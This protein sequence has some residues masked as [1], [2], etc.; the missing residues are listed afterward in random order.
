MKNIIVAKAL[1]NGEVRFK[2][3]RVGRRR[4]ISR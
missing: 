3:S 1:Y 4:R 2:I